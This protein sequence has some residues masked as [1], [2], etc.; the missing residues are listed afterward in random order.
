M[1]RRR[2]RLVRAIVTAVAQ[3]WLLGVAILLAGAVV[4]FLAGWLLGVGY[5]LA[6]LYLYLIELGFEVGR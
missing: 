4:A 6:R 1:I 5:A 3:I 2:L